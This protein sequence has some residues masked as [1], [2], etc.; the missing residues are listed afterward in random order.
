M[1]KETQLTVFLAG[2]TVEVISALACISGLEIRNA[3]V[4]VERNIS[5]GWEAMNRLLTAARDRFP[6]VRFIE[7]EIQRP[8][9][10]EFAGRGWRS[11]VRRWHTTHSIRKQ[12]DETCRAQ[13]GMDLAAFGGRVREV[14]FTVLNDYVITFLAACPRAIRVF[15]PHG[16]DHPRRQQVKDWPYLIRPRSIGTA[17]G[18]LSLQTRHFGPGGLVVG[19]IG[20]LLPGITT[21]SLPFTGV[22]QVLTFCSGITYIP[23]EV[24]K[25]PGLADIFR[26]LLQL[27][28]W[29]GLLRE[30]RDQSKGE[31][32]LLLLG[33]YNTHPI[34]EKNRDYGSVHRQLLQKVSQLTG[35]KRIVIKAHVRSDGSAAEW[36]ADYLK[37][38]EKGWN[39]EVLP[40]AL[41]GL[42]VE[43]L[44]LTGE[45]GAA[46]S[47]GS[48]SLPPAL[49]FGMPHYVSPTVA[50]VFDKGWQ[51]RSFWAKYEPGARMLIAE[52]ICLDVDRKA[53][54]AAGNAPS[55]I[56]ETRT[57]SM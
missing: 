56:E 55:F 49:G 20:A 44:A 10:D 35:L 16:F 26:W 27:P 17:L 43:A 7:L 36:L 14:Y 42:P 33:E 30:R 41:S 46:C 45:F 8:S 48:C 12:W 47:L 21:V 57:Q 15:Y 5:F 37:E 23:N 3:V 2:S 54:E 9:S 32:L 50:A 28:A 52:G 40:L 18:T 29:A 1:S 51:G 34:W 4:F 53:K 11:F 38:L 31:S 25:I 19:V 22:N 13:C 6:A 39:I 24:V